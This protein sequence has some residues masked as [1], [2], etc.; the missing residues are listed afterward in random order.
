MTLDSVLSRLNT[1]VDATDRVKAASELGELGDPKAVP[2]LEKAL[3][4]DSQSG[5]QQVAITSIIEILK[6]DA[7]D[8]IRNVME[9]HPDE[10]VKL[11][12]LQGIEMLQK[13]QIKQL[14]EILLSDSDSKI[15]AMAVKLIMNYQFEGFD[16]K[17]IELLKVED[18][19]IVLGNIFQYVAFNKL[20]SVE[21]SVLL[22]MNKVRDEDSLNYAYFSLASLGNQTGKDLFEKADYQF[23]R[24]K[25][26]G[27]FYRGKDGMR[28]LISLLRG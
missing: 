8:H 26:Q 7:I 16:D 21:A 11:N 25:F 15:R 9:N 13:P 5:V 4:E 3:W 6:E 2:Y 10:Y 18:D 1:S 20:K 28:V 23:I 27:K 24:I 22:K 19:D 12:A 14:L 17:I